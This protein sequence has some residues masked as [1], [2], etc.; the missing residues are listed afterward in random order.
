MMKNYKFNI[1]YFINITSVKFLK[2][3]GDY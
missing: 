3:E 1:I 2:L